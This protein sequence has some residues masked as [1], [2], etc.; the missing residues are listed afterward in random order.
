MNPGLPPVKQTAA[1]MLAATPAFTKG[2]G[3]TMG[4]AEPYRSDVLLEP[5]TGEESQRLTDRA[6]V[7]RAR[8]S[9]AYVRLAWLLIGP[10]ILVMLGENDGP[11]MLSYAATGA[12]YGIG[13]FLPFVALTFGMAF[14]V[15][16]A[17]IRLGAASGT[18]HAELIY[19]RFGPFWGHFAMIDLLLTNVLTLVTEFVAIVAGSGYFGVSPA[20]AVSL[21]IVLVACTPLLRRYW[22]WERLV[23]AI[24]AVNLVFVVVAILGHPA[25]GS[26]GRALVTGR[27]FPHALSSGVLVMLLSDVGATVTPWMLFFQQGAVSDKGITPKEVRVSRLDTGVGAA[28][29]ALVGIACIVA[30]APLIHRIGASA[31]QAG[32]FAQAMAPYAGHV[33]SA[34]FAIGIVEAGLV[35]IT[36][37]STS[38]AYA[39]GEVTRKSHSL[40]AAPREAPWFY[41]V[42]VLVA[43]VAGALILIPGLP[44]VNIV[45]LVNVLAVLT[46][47]PAL[48]FLN[49]LASDRE[50]MGDLTNTRLMNV[51]Q[52]AVTAFVCLAGTLYVLTLV[53][54]GL[55]L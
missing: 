15:Q 41:G 11:S 52:V 38:T 12:A 6:R 29:A 39:F 20:V 44:L 3:I 35:A 4:P 30:T 32:Q 14:V 22:R 27:P 45:L 19:R 2:R 49:L 37:I 16:E 47:P 51:L 48:V 55:R 23:L 33:G 1:Y 54:P 26:I 9:R 31:F 53:V 13:A 21:A 50:I 34:L 42:L 46:M 24:A 18:G 17:T 5:L 8:R 10:G 36:A 7:A 40:N 43:A 25:V 28:L